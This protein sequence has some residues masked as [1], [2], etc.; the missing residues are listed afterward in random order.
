MSGSRTPRLRGYLRNAALL[1]HLPVDTVVTSTRRRPVARRCFLVRHRHLGV[2]ARTTRRRYQD[3]ALD[4]AATTGERTIRRPRL[5][6]RAHRVVVGA[7]FVRCDGVGRRRERASAGTHRA[8]RVEPR[9]PERASGH[10]ERLSRRPRGGSH[11]EQPTDQGRQ[12]RTARDAPS[13]ARSSRADRTG[14]VGGSQEPRFGLVAVVAGA[15][16]LD[17]RAVGLPPGL[18]GGSRDPIRREVKN[19]PNRP[20]M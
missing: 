8:Q 5:W 15:R 12:E 18:P 4:R 1:R 9:A 16:G 14:G 7:P 2:L 10:A 19:F 6:R 13:L 20:T 17:H 11:L 3:P